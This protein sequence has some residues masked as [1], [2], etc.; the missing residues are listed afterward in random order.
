[1]F[2]L[3][4][5]FLAPSDRSFGARAS[6]DGFVN[7]LLESAGARAGTDPHHAQQLRDAAMAYLRVVR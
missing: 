5:R 3:I 4:A 2:A 7:G 6:G 1:M